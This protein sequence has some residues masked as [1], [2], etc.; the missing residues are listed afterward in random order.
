MADITSLNE[1]VSDLVGSA[2][3]ILMITLNLNMT[4]QLI[5]IITILI[6]MI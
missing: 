3:F 4:F 5:K 2:N 1:K 6:I